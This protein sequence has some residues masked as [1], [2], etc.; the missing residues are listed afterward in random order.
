M[1]IAGS[2]FIQPANVIATVDHIKKALPQLEA[3]DSFAGSM[4]EFISSCPRRD[5]M[6]PIAKR[7]RARSPYRNSMCDRWFAR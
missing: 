2:A 1:M 5:E 6:E 7:A 4:L 3:A